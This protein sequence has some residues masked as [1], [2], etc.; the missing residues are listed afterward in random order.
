MR[1][2]RSGRV[3]VRGHASGTPVGELFGVPPSGRRFEILSLDVHTVEDG[4]IV[5]T[6]HI[7]DWAARSAS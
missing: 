4:R 7:E 5:R 3:V 1:A 6:W 2:S